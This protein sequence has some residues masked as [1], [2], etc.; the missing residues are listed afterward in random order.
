M[1]GPWLNPN[2]IAS[3]D[4]AHVAAEPGFVGAHW[5][6]T[7][8][9]GRDLFVRTLEGTRMSLDGGPAAS[10][11]SLVVGV[12]YGAIAGYAGRARPTT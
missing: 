1:V 3:L 5:F 4:W 12:G 11:V 10:A 9:L 2:D 6:G 8:R 7:D